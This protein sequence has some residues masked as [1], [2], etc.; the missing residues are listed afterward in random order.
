MAQYPGRPP[1]SH[2]PPRELEISLTL[3]LKI[4]NLQVKENN[5]NVSADAG[6]LPVARL[7]YILHTQCPSFPWQPTAREPPTGSATHCSPC[8]PLP[9]EPDPSNNAHNE[10]VTWC[11]GLQS[12][13]CPVKRWPISFCHQTRW[14]FFT[15][16]LVFMAASLCWLAASDKRRE[17]RSL[18]RVQTERER[19]KQ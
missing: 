12:A 19:E 16:I 2:S 11:S 4:L 7:L 10:A 18:W 5:A 8:T 3:K 13:V 1:S 17:C 6:F 14:F 15:F 9:M